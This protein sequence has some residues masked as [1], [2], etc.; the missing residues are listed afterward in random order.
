[1]TTHQVDL[2]RW[3]MGEI[4]AV[5]A[6][7]STNRLL[8]GQDGVSV[9][10]TQ[11]ALLIFKS[12]ASATVS[13]SCAAGKAGMNDV[14]FVVKEGRVYWKHDQ[15]QAFPEG[16]F[17]IPPPPS[18]VPSVDAAFIRA[19]FSGN[20]ALLKSPFDDA[21]KSAAVTLACNQSAAEGGR[22]VKMDE[23]LGEL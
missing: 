2:L 15:L 11:A 6:S 8:K 18:E 13:T 21:L 10:D 7:Y 9:P 1:M 20:P 4:E 3:V 22:L 19:V 14:H 16:Q 5:S 17:Q 12:G 23:F